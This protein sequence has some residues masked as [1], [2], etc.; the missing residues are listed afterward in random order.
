MPIVIDI[1]RDGSLEVCLAKEDQALQTLAFDRSYEAFGI[2][3]ALRNS[4]GTEHDFH[5]TRC[6]ELAERLR[7]FR[8]AV[9]DEMTFAKS[10]P[11]HGIN[12]LSSG[13]LHPIRTWREGHA[14]D[15]NS[16]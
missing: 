7:V 11:V 9:D 15:M 8:I 3:I 1:N 4:R 12:Q 16:T 2:G 14:T 13:R 10:N 5:A 6:E